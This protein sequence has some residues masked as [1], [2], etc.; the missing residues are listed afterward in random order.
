MTVNSLHKLRW[1]L[2]GSFPNSIL[3]ASNFQGSPLPTISDVKTR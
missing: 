3:L 2:G 1:I